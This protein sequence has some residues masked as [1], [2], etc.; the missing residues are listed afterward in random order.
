MTPTNYA[1]ASTDCEQ[2]DGSSGRFLET[3]EMLAQSVRSLGVV[4]S[5]ERRLGRAAYELND[6]RPPTSPLPSQV[7]LPR[8]RSKLNDHVPFMEFDLLINSSLGSS[9][10]QATGSS[11]STDTDSIRHLDDGNA[12]QG[13]YPISA[14]ISLVNRF[15][16]GYA[17]CSVGHD[18]FDENKE[19]EENPGS[20]PAFAPPGPP[21]Q[22]RVRTFT[23]YIS[24]SG[25]E[26]LCEHVDDND[27]LMASTIIG[28]QVKTTFRSQD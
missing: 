9:L 1:E 25:A 24:I 2:K 15:S 20:A 8:W 13:K 5:G 18:R 16:F 10:D 26:S 7:E 3:D 14:F 6:G 22:G 27:S 12:V 23:S 19:G 21:K 17:C 11:G 4:A 28:Q